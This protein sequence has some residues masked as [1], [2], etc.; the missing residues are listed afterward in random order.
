MKRKILFVLMFGVLVLGLTGCGS[1]TKAKIT[2][3]NGTTKEMTYSEL[4]KELD[5]NEERFEKYYHEADIVFEDKVS[6]IE[7]STIIYA[8]LSTNGVRITFSGGWILELTS[9]YDVSEIR[10]GDVLRV[11]S[12]IYFDGY[13]FKIRDLYISVAGNGHESSIVTKVS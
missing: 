6:S 9:E 4:K 3:N 12:K 1:E 7:K 10:K 13:S 5:E 11:Q 8:T 2:D